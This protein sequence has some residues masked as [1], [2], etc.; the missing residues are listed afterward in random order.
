M[1]LFTKVLQSIGKIL[2]FSRINIV[3]LEFA[4]KSVQEVVIWPLKRPD[5]FTG[6]L[7]VPKGVLLFGPPGT[8][9]TLIGKAIAYESGATFFSISASSLTSKWVGEAEKMVKTLF[10]VAHEKQVNKA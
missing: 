9:K 7:R 8:G 4:K 5:I 6:L 2:V 1:K 10:A 3:G